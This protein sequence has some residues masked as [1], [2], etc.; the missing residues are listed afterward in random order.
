MGEERD[1]YGGAEQCTVGGGGGLL[2]GKIRN[3]GKLGI[4]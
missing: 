1:K 2:G 3:L 4:E